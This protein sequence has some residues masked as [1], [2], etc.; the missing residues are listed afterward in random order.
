[1]VAWGVDLERLHKLVSQVITGNYA[2]SS[3]SISRPFEQEESA[4]W[5]LHCQK[6]LSLSAWRE[7]LD[8]DYADDEALRQC[9]RIAASL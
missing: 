1:L 4:V 9:E 8:I 2:A 6:S 3:S 7:V 5:G